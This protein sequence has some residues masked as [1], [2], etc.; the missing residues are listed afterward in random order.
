MIFEMWFFALLYNSRLDAKIFRE[1][2]ALHALADIIQINCDIGRIGDSTIIC[3]G[4]HLPGIHGTY[5]V[6]KLV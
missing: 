4:I 6:H 2:Y 5:A 1:L 3:L